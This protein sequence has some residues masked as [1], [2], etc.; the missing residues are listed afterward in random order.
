[1]FIS[2][3]AREAHQNL[4]QAIDERC[5]E[6][7]CAQTDPEI[8]FPEKGGSVV[9]AKR[10]CAKCPARVEC[11]I[12]ALLNDELHGVFGGLSARERQIL[13]RR[14][15]EALE[16]HLREPEPKHQR[17]KRLPAHLARAKR[18][19]ESMRQA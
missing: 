17:P 16:Q 7:L 9:Q 13:R 2:R 6:P 14:S 15:P 18:R 10:L 8:F 4:M 11:L 19:L 12:F 5:G 1:M 3:E